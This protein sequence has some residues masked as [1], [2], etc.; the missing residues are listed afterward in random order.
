M[1]PRQAGDA[2]VFFHVCV[3]CAG[4]A[5]CARNVGGT[6][7]AGG[8]GGAVIVC[9]CYGAEG[10]GG[11]GGVGGGWCMLCLMM[12]GGGTMHQG[13]LLLHHLLRGI[14]WDCWCSRGSC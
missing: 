3:G 7:G 1:F 5:G 6:G 9:Y 12:E 8:A 4:G 14:F 11:V 10:G 13:H 2:S